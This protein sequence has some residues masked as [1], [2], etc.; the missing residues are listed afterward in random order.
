MGLD[1]TFVIA[2]TPQM[3]PSMAHCDVDAGLS[4]TRAPPCFDGPWEYMQV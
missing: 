3:H 1:V 2:A 4:E